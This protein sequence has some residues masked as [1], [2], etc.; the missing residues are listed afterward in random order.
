MLATRKWIGLTLAMLA[1]IAA[2]GLLSRWQWQRAQRDR[3]EAAPVPA[4]Q[5]FSPGVPL[6]ASSYGARVTASGTYDAGHQVL[7]AHGN[8]SYWVVTPLRAA[9][10]EA[11]PV[12]RASVTSPT[13][14]A[15]ADVTAG[16]VTVTG[17]AQPYEGDPGTASSLPAGQTERLTA[18]GLG[19]PYPAAGGWVALQEQVPAAAVAFSPVEPPITGDSTASIRLQNASYA[20]Q[21]L[22]FAGFVVFF[23]ARMLRDDLRGEGARQPRAEAAPVRDVY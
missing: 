1:V 10:G 9:S 4:A 13:D 20:V 14:P 21:W 15:V 19:L 3:V 17:I 22:L 8:G 11:L 12:A 7:V 2:F 5:V 23:W 18:S 6:A 16:T